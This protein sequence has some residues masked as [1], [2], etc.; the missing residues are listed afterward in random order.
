[1]HKRQPPL[2]KIKE[3]ILRRQRTIQKLS[4]CLG[5]GLSLAAFSIYQAMPGVCAPLSNA[6]RAQALGVRAREEGKQHRTHELAIKHI[7]EAIALDPKSGWL[8]FVK[9]T[10]EHEQEEEEQALS[11]VE[12]A[13]KLGT[14]AG[15]TLSLKASILNALGRA[16]EA[17]KVSQQA[18]KLDSNPSYRHAYYDILMHLGRFAQLDKEVSVELE[19]A[20][21]DWKARSARVKA[22]KFLKNWPKVI[23]D[24]TYLIDHSVNRSVLSQV[25]AFHDR[26][27]AYLNLKKYDKAEADLKA[28]I[29]LAPDTRPPHVDLLQVYK[30]TGRKDLAAKEEEKIKKLD[31]DLVGF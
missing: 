8:L 23:T 21:Q 17:L 18:M 3:G 11:D 1:M 12:R 7:N 9:A 26:G 14:S 29:K 13:I 19:K 28:A 15:A 2:A 4:A 16:E 5:L 24:I 22:S 25:Y 31:E 6:E 27:T 10:I 30:A 20:P